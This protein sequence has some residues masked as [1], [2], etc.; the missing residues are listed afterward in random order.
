MRSVS[1]LSAL[2]ATFR[3]TSAIAFSNPEANATLTKGSYYD[4][5]WTSVDTDP[6]TLSVYLVN[7]VNWPPYY[8]QL[9]LDLE[10]S[11]GEASV[12][13]PCDVDNSYGYQFNAINGTNVYIIYAQTD[14]FFIDGSSCTDPATTAST[15]A[16]PT[17]TVTQ[18]VTVRAS[19]SSSSL[20]TSSSSS[21]SLAAAPVKLENLAAANITAAA[22]TQASSA[23]SAL[24]S[25]TCP[26]TIGWSK[27]YSHPVTLTSVPVVGRGVNTA[28]QALAAEATP[29]GAAAGFFFAH[30]SNSTVTATAAASSSFSS[31]FTK[32]TSVSSAAAAASKN[33]NND[34]SNSNSNNGQFAAQEKLASSSSTKTSSCSKKR[35][36]RKRHSDGGHTRPWMQNVARN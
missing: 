26:S 25:A 15:C 19:S 30:G 9:A 29:T 13:I 23:A 8:E 22:F 1:I 3:L 12:R 14:K 4:L 16:A 7:F 18:T 36:Q 31:S 17:A 5:A 10:V 20:T 6:T 28:S 11:A 34:N 33:N 35:Q 27:D 32:S 24:V 21:S 2:A